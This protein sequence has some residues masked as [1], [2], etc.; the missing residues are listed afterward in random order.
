MHLKNLIDKELIDKE[1]KE[2]AALSHPL[3]HFKR[4]TQSSIDLQ[5]TLNVLVQNL[6]HSYK[7]W[8]EAE[9]LQSFPEVKVLDP[10]LNPVSMPKEPEMSKISR[11]KDT[12]SRIDLPGKQFVGSWWMTWS[13]TSLS[14]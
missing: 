11:L 3:S 9:T 5:Y 1:Y 6:D 2:G 4:G 14:L 13:I 8:A 10:V 12:S 7:T